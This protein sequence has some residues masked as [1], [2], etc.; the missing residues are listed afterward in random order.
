MRKGPK[1]PFSYYLLTSPHASYVVAMSWFEDFRRKNMAACVTEHPYQDKRYYHVWV[2]YDP[3]L[4]GSNVIPERQRGI[5]LFGK[6][7]HSCG[8]F[9]ERLDRDKR[10]RTR[11][12]YGTDPSYL[13]DLN[14]LGEEE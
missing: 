14:I 9:R 8:G 6:I 4:F 7:I 11:T 13:A 2:E 12:N 3:E 5:A 10:L 1:H